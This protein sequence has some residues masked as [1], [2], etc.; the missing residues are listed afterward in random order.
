MPTTTTT[1]IATSAGAV[2]ENLRT[3]YGPQA[4]AIGQVAATAYF[5]HLQTLQVLSIFV[6][7]FF[8]VATVYFAIKTGWIRTRIDRVQDVVLKKDVIRKRVRK[9]WDDIERHFFV[10]DDNDLKIAI[11][12]AD[13]L[14]DDALRAIGVPGVQLGDK[15]KKVRES[16]LPNVEDVWQAHKLRNRIAHESNF[17]LKRD[18]AE[19]ALTVYEKALEHLGALEPEEKTTEAPPRSRRS[20]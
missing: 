13:K 9:S 19:R 6:T 18:L 4:E 3:N 8:I 11:V 20:R 5:S 12:E 7:A 10:G 15:L 2:L 1:T 16:Q 17:T 14:L